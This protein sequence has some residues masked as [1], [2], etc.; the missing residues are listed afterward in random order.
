MTTERGWYGG[1]VG[2]W[3][4]GMMGWW[5]VGISV[6]C[7]LIAALGA[8]IKI[9]ALNCLFGVNNPC[10]CLLPSTH[11][12]GGPAPSTATITLTSGV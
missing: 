7:A 1:M 6:H 4:G 11:A 3:G 9:N 5:E 12:S 2:R 10:P 8:E